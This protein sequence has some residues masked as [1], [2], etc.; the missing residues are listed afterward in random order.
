MISS[1]IGDMRMLSNTC[2]IAQ[3][4]EMIISLM[5]MMMKIM[6]VCKVILSGLSLTWL[7]FLKTRQEPS[8]L[9]LKVTRS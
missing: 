7:S 3:K 8:N 5:E 4:T 9:M 6:M 1:A 2:P